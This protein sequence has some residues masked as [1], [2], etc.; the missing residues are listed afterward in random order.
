[1]CA[2]SLVAAQGQNRRLRPQQTAAVQ[3]EVGRLPLR[4]SEAATLRCRTVAVGIAADGPPAAAD[5]AALAAQQ[6]VNALSG[7]R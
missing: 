3:L 4:S 1:M 6:H 2:C 5:V 7:L